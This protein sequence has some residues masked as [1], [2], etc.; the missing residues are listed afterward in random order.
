MRAIVLIIVGIIGLYVPWHN[1]PAAKEKGEVWRRDTGLLPQYCKDRAK[2][3]Q[4]PEWTRWRGT[5]GEAYIHMHHYC[6]GLY[7]EQQ[8]KL[9][10]KQ[11]GR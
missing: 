11:G 8:A 9:A 7:A 2:G 10:M 3:T 1:L 5:F 4:S 6:M